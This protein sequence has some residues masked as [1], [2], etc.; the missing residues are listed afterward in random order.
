MQLVI[1]PLK[2]YL[3]ITSGLYGTS[4]TLLTSNFKQNL[5]IQ[6]VCIKNETK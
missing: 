3:K 4:C 6:H 5:I 1:R 2:S